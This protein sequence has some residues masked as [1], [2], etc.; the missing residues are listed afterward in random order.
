MVFDRVSDE[1]PPNFP[2]F[3]HVYGSIA[4]SEFVPSS[5]D[6]VFTGVYGEGNN[7]GIICVS[8]LS[9]IDGKS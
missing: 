5:I 2:H 9:S 7:M 1:R 4:Q 3:F 8:F 6:H